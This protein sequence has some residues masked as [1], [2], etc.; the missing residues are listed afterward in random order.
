[1]IKLRTILGKRCG[2]TLLELIITVIIVGILLCL[3][4]G[5]IITCSAMF[6]KTE[7]TAV[8]VEKMKDGSVYRPL[9]KLP[10][11]GKVSG[12]CAGIAYKWGID[13]WIPRVV[14]IVM[15][16]VVGGGLLVYVVLALLLDSA[17][18][19]VDYKLRISQ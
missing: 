14:F 19:P 5:G 1:M 3:F 13:P 17:P 16:F 8:A 11:Q 9:V 2:F 10:D 15:T 4:F 7:Y 12:V 18:T 6:K